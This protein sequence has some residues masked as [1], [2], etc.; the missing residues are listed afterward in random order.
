MDFLFVYEAC[1]KRF[2]DNFQ[3]RAA[4]QTKGHNLQL[5]RLLKLE[6]I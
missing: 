5:V 4:H 3:L 6:L 2:E 1:V